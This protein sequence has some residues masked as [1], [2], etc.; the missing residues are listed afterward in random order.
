M[1]VTAPYP[2]AHLQELQQLVGAIHY[3]PWTALGRA[4]S[5]M[6]LGRLIEQSGADAI[7]VELDEVDKQVLEERKLAF[8]G[9]CRATPV[10]V[11]VLKAK[12]KGI[13]LF[14]APGR[15]V[16]AVAEL[17]IATII[18]MLRHLRQSEK[19]LKAENWQNRFDPYHRF[20]GLELFGKKVGIVGMGAVGQRVSQLLQAFSCPIS[21]F[22]PY[23][24]AD[25][26]P[27][28]QACSLEELFSQND[29]VSIHLPEKEE[30]AG[31]INRSLLQKMKPHALFVNTSRASVVD[32]DSLVELL[33]T[34]KIFGAILDVFHQEPPDVA[35]YRLIQLDNVLA[36]PHI[37]GASLDVAYH[38]ANSINRQIR[39]WIKTGRQLV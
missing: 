37:A 11:D 22:D 17:V 16:Q 6:E 29:I 13:P 3:S 19:W 30:T 28:Y 14:R 33:E 31:M 35:D 9:V 36:T 38:H 4:R 26:F 7:I 24:E 1:L 18:S 23:V 32:R 27:D 2:K 15:N 10:N 20:Q 21:Y 34:N 25:Q 8:V 12:E 5:G 39:E